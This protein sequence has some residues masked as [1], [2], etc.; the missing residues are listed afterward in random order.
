MHFLKE[1]FPGDETPV[2][3][4]DFFVQKPA[5]LLNKDYL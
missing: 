1:K 5:D 2:G 4:A 3:I